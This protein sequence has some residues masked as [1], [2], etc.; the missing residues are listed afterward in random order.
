M[1]FKLRLCCSC[2]RK[3]ESESLLYTSSISIR[4]TRKT[5]L[6][7]RERSSIEECHE[8]KLVERIRGTTSLRI[9]ERDDFIIN[10][11]L[12]QGSSSTVCLLVTATDKRKFAGKMLKQGSCWS[13]INEA[14]I[15]KQFS[16][17]CPNIACVEGIIVNPKCLVLQYY[18]NGDL[19][20]ALMRDNEKVDSGSTSEFPFLKRLRYIRDAC[21]AVSFLHKSCVCHRDLAMRNLLLSDD[22]E[23]V[24]LS[25][26]T[27]S[28]VVGDVLNSQITFTADLPTF[29][30]PETFSSGEADSPTQGRHGW[31]YSLRSDIYA[32]GMTMFEVITK[33]HFL[34]PTHHKHRLPTELPED[35]LPPKH[36]FNRAWD[37]WF[38]IRRCWNTE[39]EKRPWSWELLD[40]ISE[41]LRNPISSDTSGIYYDRYSPKSSQ[42]SSPT[43]N[44]TNRKNSVPS[45]WSMGL[46][47]TVSSDMDYSEFGNETLP[48]PPL[49]VDGDRNHVSSNIKT[50]DKNSK[51]NFQNPNSNPGKNGA[52]DSTTLSI[53]TG[54]YVS[55]LMTGKSSTSSKYCDPMSYAHTNSSLTNNAY[56]SKDWHFFKD[57]ATEMITLPEAFITS[58]CCN[59]D[60]SSAEQSYSSDTDQPDDSLLIL[61][62]NEASPESK[63]SVMSPVS[64]LRI[65][66]KTSAGIAII[67]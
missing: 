16:R 9:F 56:N 18:K 55:T 52:M 39:I 45:R 22:M 17:L 24:L 44:A 59:A 62:E 14:S 2:C 65:L 49:V 6:F 28:R 11:E 66:S 21:K 5:S 4:S 31:Q 54:S 61:M 10:R 20:T 64:E 67:L 48:R 25:D 43:A 30:A 60:D 19:G 53:S 46:M 12:G 51:M 8:R 40:N 3:L 41:L 34:R 36:L 23:H 50:R 32:L 57:N 29:S 26:F 7:S 58:D 47:T 1:S 33:K 13:L 35:I 42:E 63:S 37:L 27:L 38:A 15:M